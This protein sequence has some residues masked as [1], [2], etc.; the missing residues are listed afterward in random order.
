MSPRVHFQPADP[1]APY[2]VGAFSL[3]EVMAALGL[4][5]LLTGVVA[6]VLPAVSHRRLSFQAAADLALLVAALEGYRAEWG[7]YP[8]TGDRPHFSGLTGPVPSHAAEAALHAALSGRADPL[9]QRVG[10]RARLALGTVPTLLASRSDLAASGTGEADVY[11]DPWGR[12]YVYAYRPPAPLAPWRAEGYV[13]YSCG[14]DGRH[15][16]PVEGRYD[17]SHPDN[18]DNVVALP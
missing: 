14:P 7:D 9:L 5:A 18:S 8:R 11:V 17:A 12:P 1:A 4:A 16:E 2:R 15:G 13:L 6:G 10:T 3:L